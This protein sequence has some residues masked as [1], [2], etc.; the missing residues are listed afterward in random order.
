MPEISPDDAALRAM[1]A[2]LFTSPQR[3]FN[4]LTHRVERRFLIEPHQH[5]D[6]LQLDLL[7]GCG[8]QAWSQSRWLPIG[9]V[10]ALVAYPHEPHGY[11]L[12]PGDPPSRVYHLKL[13]V[14]SDNPLV[15]RR[16][17]PRC[18]TGLSAD[19][20]VVAAMR[21]VMAGTAP[22]QRS[23][24][25]AVRLAEVICLW[26]RS[27][28]PAPPT[29]AGDDAPI[30]PWLADA[31]QTIQDRPADPPPLAELAE[32]AG[33]SVRH[34]SRLFTTRLGTTPHAYI[35][36]RRRALASELLLGNQ[37]KVR[38]IA[39][40]VGFSSVATFSRWFRTQTGSAPRD[41]R[42]DPTIM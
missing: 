7:V 8:G 26:P 24:L 31:M 22:Q 33:M 2:E 21:Q 1:C 19:Q 20:P 28:R 32:S 30:P 35:N 29:G 40:A 23:P 34:F 14:G 38:Q 12:L 5:A 11:D 9:G 27:G 13:R 4:T 16:L 42:R 39:E 25:H 15:R 36:H 18:V 6:L 10:T 3:L 41:F 37:L 17:L